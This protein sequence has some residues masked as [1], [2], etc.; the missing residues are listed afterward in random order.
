MH[1][2]ARHPR[3][4]FDSPKTQ[5]IYW[6]DCTL[7]DGGIHNL[8]NYVLVALVALTLVRPCVAQ[9]TRKP[10]YPELFE[11]V[12]QTI[13]DNF[14]D[15]SFGGVDWKAMRRKYQPEVAKVTDDNSF[16]ALAY[17]M[18]RELHVSH[19]DLVPRQL[20]QSGI[21]VRSK[22]IEEKRII[23]TVA[24]ASDAQKQGLR[25]GD[26]L[27]TPPNE[28]IG[29]IGTPATVRVQDCDG[30]ERGLQVRRENPLTTS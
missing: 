25:V 9:D 23:T 16:T 11:A 14:Y 20:V 8:K 17:R 13:N 10:T 26:L 21:A 30:R 19:L 28:L 3:G 18:M 6:R 2:L 4:D 27:I 7:F 12:W 15:P 29:Q 5:I 24:T 22:R 1:I